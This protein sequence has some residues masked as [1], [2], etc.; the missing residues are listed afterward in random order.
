M[1]DAI[2][3]TDGAKVTKVTPVGENASRAGLAPNEPINIEP[4]VNIGVNNTNG[5]ITY[6]KYP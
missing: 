4:K 6:R 5:S 3:G 1:Y 2:G